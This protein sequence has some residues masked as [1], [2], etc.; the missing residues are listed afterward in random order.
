MSVLSDQIPE[1]WYAIAFEARSVEMAWTDWTGPEIDRVVKILQPRGNETVLDRACGSSRQSL[2]LRR[3]GFAVVGADISL[4]LI[5]IARREA[6]EED[7]DF[8]FVLADLRDLDFEHEFDLV[9][10]T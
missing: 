5:G 7:L 10:L 4:D 6:A 9:R 8:N 2:D 3:R 1:D